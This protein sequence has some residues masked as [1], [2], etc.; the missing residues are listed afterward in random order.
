MSHRQFHCISV[1]IPVQ[2]QTKNKYDQS[3][4]ELCRQSVEHTF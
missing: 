2:E 1:R 4:I 3:D